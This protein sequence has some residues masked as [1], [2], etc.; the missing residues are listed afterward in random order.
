M[1]EA[2]KLTTDGMLLNWLKSVGDSVKAGDIIAEFEADKATVEVESTANGVL[3]ELKAEVGQELKEGAIIAIV[4]ASGEATAPTPTPTASTNGSNG[5]AT[6]KPTSAPTS[7]PVVASTTPEGRIK[8]SPL[9]RNVAADKGIDLTTVAGTGP[10]GRIVRA[11]VDNYQP[12]TTPSTPVGKAEAQPTVSVGGR[13]TY[14]TIPTEDVEILD[15]SRMRRA[16][17]DNTIISKQMTPHFYVT[18]SVDV[19]PLLKLRS[20]LNANLEGDA[21]ISVNDLIVKAT[22]LALRKFPNLNSHY[23]GDKIVRHTRIN[24]GIAVA[25]PNNG[26]LNVVAKD[27]DKMALSTMAVTNKAMFER[28]REGKIKP[29]DIKGA[30]FTVSNLGPYQV[31]SFSAIIS[32]PEAGILAVS[33]A[34]KVPIVLED[35][36]IGVGER[37]NI[38]L[39]V[40]HR[41]SDGAEGAQFMVELRALIE[42]PMRLLV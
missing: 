17:A 26:L 40:D 23:Y 12:S 25:L 42:N 3:L 34:K 8:A 30:T 36:T 4:G 41:V 22:A 20:Q 31:D 7:Q 1:S 28:A 16:I 9:A 13:N 38:T 21:K 15:V 35:G 29:D 6:P 14:G 2:I 33:S 10:G 27:A 32:P 19:A 37:M 5:S 24:I 18:V 39:S 11:D